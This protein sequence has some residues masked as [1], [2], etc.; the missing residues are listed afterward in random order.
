MLQAVGIL[1]M[2]PIAALIPICLMK[3]YGYPK[4]MAIRLKQQMNS[5]L[6]T[7]KLVQLL[8]L[9]QH[10]VQLSLKQPVEVPAFLLIAL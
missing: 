1:S 7:I 2:T 6:S 5:S 10:S 9:L 3:S 8:F 4:L